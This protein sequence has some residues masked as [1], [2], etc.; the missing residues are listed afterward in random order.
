MIDGMTYDVWPNIHLLPIRTWRRNHKE[1]KQLTPVMYIADFSLARKIIDLGPTNA[2]LIITTFGKSILW[3][4]FTRHFY[5][6]EIIFKV[7]CQT[8]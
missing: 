8:S 1:H 5:D 4:F 2:I 3:Y 7:F 6:L